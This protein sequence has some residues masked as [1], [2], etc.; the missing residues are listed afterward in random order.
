MRRVAIYAREDPT[1][2]AQAR[3]DAQIATAA[4]FVRRQRGWHV[5]TYTDLSPAATLQRPGLARLIAHAPAGWF[6][7]VVVERRD[8][9]APD[10]ALSRQVREQL[11]TAG[12]TV[13]V[14]RP[15]L[16]ARLGRVVAGLA[17]V[18]LVQD[19]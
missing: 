19:R 2:G 1:A 9:V 16:A 8:T 4:A 10:P 14:I 18:D 13:V 3:L 15:P 11:A 6:E 5:A 7:L 12:V 17:L